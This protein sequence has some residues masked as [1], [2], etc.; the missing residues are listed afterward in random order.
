[1][2][3][4]SP[5][6][7]LSGYRIPVSSTHPQT[8]GS[9]VRSDP[10]P[11]VAR[12]FALAI[13]LVVVAFLGLLVWGLG[14][15][16]AGTVGVAPIQTRPAPDFGLPLFDGG[17]FRLGEQRGTPVLINFWASWCVPCEDE[18]AALERAYRQYGDRVQFI[19]VNVQD[20]DANARAFLRRFGVSY[21]NGRDASGEV[22]VEYGMSGVPETYFVDR[23]GT[24]VRKW[25]GPLDDE[26]LRQF[27]DELAR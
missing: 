7:K 3:F 5:D 19:G 22:A 14:R 25:Q 6:D 10:N 9:D 8:L 20:T 27:L 1:M 15:R 4:F 13:A 21:P 12:S 17:T 18:A 23:N 24:L 26:R 2:V 11:W 16:A